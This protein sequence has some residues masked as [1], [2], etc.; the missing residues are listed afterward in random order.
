MILS[1]SRKVVSPCHPRWL[2]DP[3]IGSRHAASP[4]RPD[5]EQL[6]SAPPSSGLNFS[7]V[8][9]IMKRFRQLDLKAFITGIKALKKRQNLTDNTQS[10][11]SNIKRL[12]NFFLND[13]VMSTPKQLKKI[14]NRH[15][16]INKAF[17]KTLKALKEKTLR[18]KQQEFQKV[19]HSIT[20]RS[21]FDKIINRHINKAS[22][23]W[24]R[25][26]S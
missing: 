18:T 14:I 1:F 25:K 12:L 3:W 5:A 9:Y 24:K 19:V 2:R 4:Y 13:Y 17:I 7:S 26:S 23:L 21:Y 16:C 22:K 6:P 15:I 8:D 20:Y 10:N 11:N